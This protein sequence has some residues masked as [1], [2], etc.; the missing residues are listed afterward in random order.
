MWDANGQPVLTF[1]CSD[2][3]KMPPEFLL[4]ILPLLP[5]EKTYS[6]FATVGILLPCSLQAFS[7]YTP[8]QL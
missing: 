3:F 2:E 4:I 5:V 1:M 6:A 8:K 7:P